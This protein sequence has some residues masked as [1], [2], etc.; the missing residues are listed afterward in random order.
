MKTL[1]DITNQNGG[2]LSVEVTGK[3]T[4]VRHAKAKENGKLTSGEASKT[5]RKKG[6]KIS[7][8]E[9]VEVYKLL[10]G[11]E[12]EWHHAGFYKNAGRSTMGRTFFFTER[13]INEIESRIG[14]IEILREE[15]RK[16]EERKANSVITGFYYIWDHD[17]SGR[18]GKKRNYKVLK[19]YKGSELKTPKNFTSCNES[20][21]RRVLENE[22]KNYYGWDEPTINEF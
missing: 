6:L 7:A 12:P 22:G 14:E 19:A 4:S 18:Y 13:Q 10:F 16:E 8:K 2:G 17:Y 11:T 21:F 9:L 3:Y 15:K 1:N 20:Q 5:L